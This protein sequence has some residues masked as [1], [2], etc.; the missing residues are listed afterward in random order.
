ML[1][2]IT[3]KGRDFV[4]RITDGGFYKPKYFKDWQDWILL[5]LIIREG[6]LDT[7]NL[8]SEISSKMDATTDPKSMSEWRQVIKRVFEA[9]YIEQVE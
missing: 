5:D 3:S 6:S 1:V 4:D 2:D 8:E 7:L 9:G